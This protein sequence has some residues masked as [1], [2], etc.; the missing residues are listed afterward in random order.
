MSTPLRDNPMGL[1]ADSEEQAPGEVLT[2]GSRSAEL[3]RLREPPS[4]SLCAYT[5]GEV[6]TLMGLLELDAAAAGPWL[7][8]G[9]GHG[10]LPLL[11]AGV[12]RVV[13]ADLASSHLA[14]A[15]NA[16]LLG[17]DADDGGTL[18]MTTTLAQPASYDDGRAF[19]AVGVVWPRALAHAEALLARLGATL[20]ADT[21]VVVG[22]RND[23]PGARGAR[24]LERHLSAL[25]IERARG[26]RR[27][28]VGKLRPALPP[29]AKSHRGPDGIQIWSHAGV[30][31]HGR[32]DEGAT[33][34]IDALA[35]AELPP[36]RVVLDLG[37]GDGTLGVVA[38]GRTGAAKV[39]FVDDDV[40]AVDAARLTFDAAFAA[41]EGG[42]AANAPVADYVHACDL[43]SIAARSVDLVVCNP[44]FHD[45]AAMT[46]ATA[47]RM[48]AD[49][50]RVLDG[51]GSLLVVGNRHLD[52]DTRLLRHF[53]A[54][55]VVAADRAFVVLRARHPRRS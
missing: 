35:F 19:A 37:C 10:A 43:D 41:P 16:E 23:G 32:V 26:R 2:V 30:F 18:H 28:A 33:R 5:H 12:P 4:S 36:G 21:P 38:A 39:I 8:I 24:L 25:T 31:A 13:V 22:M 53:A 7:I 9:D 3:R 44:P 17:R 40:M 47:A 45:G 48:F 52:Y 29:V 6:A 14:A 49:A 51:N 42:L 54:V 11:P 55:H 50:A 34:L 27:I 1:F 15:M 46:R 20:P